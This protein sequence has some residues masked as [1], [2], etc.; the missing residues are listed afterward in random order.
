MNTTTDNLT[1]TYY[2]A[3]PGARTWREARDLTINGK[4]VSAVVD[5][6]NAAVFIG[7]EI[8]FEGELPAEIAAAGQ[9]ATWAREIALDAA[10]TEA[11]A[12]DTAEA[13]VAE[14]IV[15][16][17]AGTV[18]AE[19]SAVA[20]T[21]G[22]HRAAA[23]AFTKAKGESIDRC[24]TDGALSQWAYGLNAAEHHLAARIAEDGG[25]AEFAGLFDLEGNLV[26]AVRVDGRYGWYWKLL[27]AN[28]RTAGLF[29]ESR[30]KT[31]DRRRA[32]NARKGYYVGRVRVPARAILA[33]GGIGCVL[34]IAERLDG[35]YSADAEIIDN[36]HR[37]PAHA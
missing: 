26:P 18:A 19:L 9:V 32:A 35:G 8:A 20:V 12:V 36:G 15:A 3:A 16:E 33:G 22:E 10:A 14:A 21:A 6:R 29:N 27:D 31:A 37:A 4:R 25:M 5:G 11:A 7:G 1:G 17:A 24:D 30:A 34:P 28:G 13:I 2:P 23:D